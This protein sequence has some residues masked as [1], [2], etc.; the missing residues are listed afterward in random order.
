MKD[1]TK[2][3][4]LIIFWLLIIIAG[5]IILIMT[6]VS[7]QETNSTIQ[8]NNTENVTFTGCSSQLV[9]YLKDANF[10]LQDEL[11]ARDKEIDSLK[12]Y[13]TTTYFLAFV[14]A[15]LLVWQVYQLFRK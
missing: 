7:S 12:Y 15:F 5:I 2:E 10:Q 13:K 1:N 11:D 6:V 3:I 9:S 8:I 4:L 14:T